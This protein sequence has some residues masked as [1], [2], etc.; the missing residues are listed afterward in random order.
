MPA[1]DTSADT[2]EGSGLTP[3]QEAECWTSSMGSIGCVLQCPPEALFNAWA[4]ERQELYKRLEPNAPLR[5]VAP[6]TDIPASHRIM[7]GPLVSDAVW[8]VVLG[9]HEAAGLRHVL[10]TAAQLTDP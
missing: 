3:E 7:V 2:A 1:M 9:N 8:Q 10:K 6:P 4:R 5:D